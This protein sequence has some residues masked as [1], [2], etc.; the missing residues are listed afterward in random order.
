M[1]PTRDRVLFPVWEVEPG[2]YELEAGEAYGIT[3][4]AKFNIYATEDP[5][6]KC[7]GVLVAETTTA[8]TTKLHPLPDTS[9]FTLSS[10]EG[11]ALQT[12]V[13]EK[14][15]LKVF[16]AKDDQ[17]LEVYQRV[18]DEMDKHRSLGKRGIL[19][20]EMDE[21]PDVLLTMQGNGVVFEITDK[22]CVDRG[23]TIMHEPVEC[24]ADDIFPVI[25]SAADFYYHL[26]RTSSDRRLTDLVKLE[27]TELEKTGKWTKGLEPLLKEKGENL[28]SQGVVN[29]VAGGRC[30]GFK[31][32]N[33]SA[34]PLYVA[35]FHFNMCDLN[36]SKLFLQTMFS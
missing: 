26:R 8:F 30:Y 2:L 31:V 9:P 32:T 16:I 19:P 7:L 15:D 21:S 23:L 28:I 20:V 14:Q 11:Y 24:N 22:F 36:I 34:L 6:S 25:A 33:E 1:V 10:Q 5:N 18:K 35:L 3:T 27:C 13:G 4:G 29:V 12:S 17:L